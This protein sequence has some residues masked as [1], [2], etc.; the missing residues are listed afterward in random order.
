MVLVAFGLSCKKNYVPML[1][2]AVRGIT[3]ALAAIAILTISIAFPY[4]SA[5]NLQ[6]VDSLDDRIGTTDAAASSRW[7]L[8]TAMEGAIKE[9]PLTGYGLGA[10]ISYQSQDPRV[11]AQNPNGTYTTF[12]FEWGWLDHWF[13]LGVFGLLAVLILVLR[14]ANRIVHTEH[15]PRWVRRALLASVI[16]LVATHFF[17]PYLNH[18]LGLGYLLML[19]GWCAV[20][21]HKKD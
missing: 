13:K 20:Y 21:R 19:E 8:L 15:A 10:T 17:T 9:R 12:A 2:T 5:P 3:I 11:L 1:W 16:A 4:P 7:E 14:I 18:P 6:N